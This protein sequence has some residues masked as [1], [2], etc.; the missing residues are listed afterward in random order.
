MSQPEQTLLAD[1]TAK[2]MNNTLDN[3]FHPFNVDKEEIIKILLIT[4]VITQVTIPFKT[5][6]KTIQ[7][8]S[9]RPL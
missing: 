9:A 1:V 8:S 3:L 4:P 7:M 6:L 2:V 5:T